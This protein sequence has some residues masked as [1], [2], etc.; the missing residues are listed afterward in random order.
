MPTMRK[1][2]AIPANSPHFAVIKLAST[3]TAIG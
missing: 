2:V 1:T 3:K